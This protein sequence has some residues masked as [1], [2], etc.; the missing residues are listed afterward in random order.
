MELPESN[1][2]NEDNEDVREQKKTS[3]RFNDAF[4]E[5]VPDDN[6]GWEDDSKDEAGDGECQDQF[7]D[8]ENSLPVANQEYLIRFRNAAFTWG[9]KSDALLEIEDLDIPTGIKDVL[10]QIRSI[11][12]KVG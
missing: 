8:E 12:K 4:V 2:V 11:K 7:S 9:M 6:F 3:D 10:F 1:N 5:N